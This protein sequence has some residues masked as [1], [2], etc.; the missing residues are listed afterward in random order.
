MEKKKKKGGGVC[1]ASSADGRCPQKK[2]ACE[3][4]VEGGERRTKTD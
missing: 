3:W 1:Q 2:C 4:G